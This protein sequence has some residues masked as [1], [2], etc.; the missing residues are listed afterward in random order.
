M[1]VD[2]MNQDGPLVVAGIGCRRGAAASDIEAAV[3]TAL[4]RAG[5]APKALA[6]IATIEAKR[7]EVGVRAA[8]E[9]FGVAVIFISNSELKTASTRTKTWSERTLAIMGVPSVAEA[10]A[11]AAAGPGARLLAPRLVVG[12]ATCA[13][14][15][16]MTAPEAVS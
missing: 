4:Q 8:A 1:G 16:V 15:V 11:L 6:M 7:A 10:A 9:K 14:A 12:A 2:Q 5:I 3:H 13:L